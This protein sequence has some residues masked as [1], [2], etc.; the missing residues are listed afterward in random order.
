LYFLAKHYKQKKGGFFLIQGKKRMRRS[1]FL[2]WLLTVMLVF[3]VF[4]IPFESY[5]AED[6]GTITIT[7][8][9]DG[10]LFDNG[11]SVLV[12]EVESGTNLSD[13]FYA[14]G[15]DALARLPKKEGYGIK[16]WTVQIE[17]QD[18]YEDYDYF[19]DVCVEA[20][21]E[22]HPFWEKL[23]ERV[24]IYFDCGNEA[25][26][27]D[28]GPGASST[29]WYEIIKGSTLHGGPEAFLHGCEFL[30]WRRD[31]G[32]YYSAEEFESAGIVCDR[33]MTFYAVW[34][35]GSNTYDLTW[36]P[37][38]GGFNSYG[39]VDGS[40]RWTR[41]TEPKVQIFV[42]GEDS[43][44]E[45]EASI[46]NGVRS[47]GGW[48]I[49]GG[50]YDGQ[51]IYDSEEFDAL[52]ITEDLLFQAQWIEPE[53]YKVTWDPNGGV[54]YHW[55]VDTQ[56]GEYSAEP[57]V[58]YFESSSDFYEQYPER[59]G[60]FMD[61]WKIVG[62]TADGTV[63]HS[64]DFGNYELTEDLYLLCQW[65]EY[66][67]LYNE[68]TLPDQVKDA[69]TV[70]VGTTYVEGK[71]TIT[72][73]Y[74]KIFMDQDTCEFSEEMVTG[75]GYFFVFA[76]GPKKAAKIEVIGSGEAG[77]DSPFYIYRVCQYDGVYDYESMR[78]EITGYVDSYG[79]Y[80]DGVGRTFALANADSVRE[81]VYIFIPKGS[82]VK[83]FTLKAETI[84]SYKDG[85]AYIG[86]VADSFFDYVDDYALAVTAGEAFDLNEAEVINPAVCIEADSC[87]NTGPVWH[88]AN[89]RGRLLRVSLPDDGSRWRLSLKSEQYGT[90]GIW[91]SE[92]YTGYYFQ[93]I[94]DYNGNFSLYLS[95]HFAAEYGND[96]IVFLPEDVSLDLG[97]RRIVT[98]DDLSPALEKDKVNIVAWDD[99]LE[100][101][102]KQ[103]RTSNPELYGKINFISLGWYVGNEY[104]NMLLDVAAGKYDGYT[105]L[106]AIDVSQLSV[107]EKYPAIKKIG[108]TEADYEQSYQYLKDLGTVGG[109]L[110]AVSWQA[111]PSGFFY[112][113]EIAEEV[114]GTSDPVEIQKL[115]STPAKFSAVAAQMKAA[116][117]FMT[118][119][120]YN[121]AAYPE[122]YSYDTSLWNTAL[123]ELCKTY[124]PLIY[125]AGDGEWSTTW[126][127]GMSNK[128]VFGYFGTTWLGSTI[129]IYANGQ[130]FG[131]CEGPVSYYRGG[132]FIAAANRGSMGTEAG[133]VLRAFLC[134]TD[135]QIERTVEGKGFA[136]VNN[137][138]A[139][140]QMILSETMKGAT[141]SDQDFLPVWHHSALVLGGEEKVEFVPGW[142]EI[143]GKKYYF[144]E[145]GTK[146]VGA[147]KIDQ[148]YYYFDQ[149]GVMQTGWI[150]IGSKRY[151]MNL[152][153]GAMVTGGQKIGGK[154]YYFNSK[155]VMQTGWITLN[156][157]RYYMNP[158]TGE[159]VTGVQ[160]IS[161]K[162][163]YFNEKGIMQTGWIIVKGKTFHLGADGA[164]E[165]GWVTV[166][167]SLYYLGTNGVMQSGGWLV[168][169][170][171]T[172]YLNEDGKAQTGWKLID[173][174]Y[175][176]FTSKG[177]MMT[178]WTQYKGHSY[179]LNADGTMQTGWK[180]IGGKYYRFSSKGVMLT[181]WTTY[182]GNTYYL[183]ETGVMVTNCTMV[184]DGVEYT[185][186]KSGV[187]TNKN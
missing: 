18:A 108:F 102:M 174:N 103:V 159:A 12:L 72:A 179:Y 61:G 122:D 46:S 53:G 52:E 110:R 75:E 56:T 128:S 111:C 162:T 186:N 79:G 23:P 146:A 85:I 47:F 62:G 126:G 95:E 147:Q 121:R 82:V 169:E 1:R 20:N 151:F 13:L 124:D 21:V 139:N 149:E 31:D 161:G 57:L 90:A 50:T 25:G 30:G 181:G 33:E 155:G 9:G 32:V 84:T 171:K 170:D 10:G 176:C 11:D 166:D 129:S 125:D 48:K 28:P 109:K 138:A 80:W 184:I 22:L 141:L 105:I 160:K 2:A 143:D 168:L 137:K 8:Y 39:Y 113:L 37:N 163:Y 63:L 86:P 96:L 98:P 142:N 77:W 81:L 145:D 88:T 180:K 41:V 130:Q 119:G 132:E 44:P 60:Y 156:K 94:D 29:T 34:E 100:K 153:T 78:N 65:E 3:S 74:P 27:L 43:Y 115:I 154:I 19:S 117:Y 182:K 59:D 58:E 6:A 35:K 140:E 17:G 144:L 120:L 104:K 118:A 112:N 106:V 127:N 49:I 92:G 14:P 87:Q 175:Y 83:G 51:I 173:N 76:L 7:A 185:F 36:D 73:T 38:G 55:D 136:V 148:E 99:A 187:C 42:T 133:E 70:K 97:W 134:D 158:E 64:E 91:D 107:L 69:I 54:L 165:T 66:V 71:S 114:L 26:I 40:W 164:M 101:Q 45:Y 68:S 93:P 67:P 172:Y 157:K 116:G 135:V 152:T 131:L 178:G 177:V 123:N 4:Q 16:G 24:K 183:D 89:V 5:A 167:G 150:T 15:Y